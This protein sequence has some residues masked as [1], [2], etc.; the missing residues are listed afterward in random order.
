VGIIEPVERAFSRLILRPRPD[1][2]DPELTRWAAIQGVLTIAGTKRPKVRLEAYRD[3]GETETRR[4]LK[5]IGEAAAKLADAIAPMHATTI[6]ALADRGVVRGALPSP[7]ALRAVAAACLTATPPVVAPAI[8]KKGRPGNMLETGLAIVLR[9]DFEDL[10]GKTANQAHANE[11]GSG[12]EPFAKEILIA[13]GVDPT[14]A[15][16]A[17]N[18]ALRD[19]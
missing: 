15:A 18:A 2:S 3:L 1:G 11:R 4:E 5:K 12:F 6:V 8:T 9:R 17:I 13:I 14:R 16:T 10:T 7:A 19:Y